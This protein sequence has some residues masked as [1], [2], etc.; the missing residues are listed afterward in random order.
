MHF[1]RIAPGH[2]TTDKEK[3]VHNNDRYR[4]DRFNEPETGRDA[5][6]LTYPGEFNPDDVFYS[7]SDA[8][9]AAIEHHIMGG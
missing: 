2:Y 8:K 5:W 6:T 4:I 1:Y 7:Y 9:A 3:D